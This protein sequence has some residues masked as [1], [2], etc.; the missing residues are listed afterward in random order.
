MKKNLLFIALVFIL[1]SFA[2]AQ[3]SSITVWPGTSGNIVT[4]LSSFNANEAIYLSSEVGSTNFLTAGTAINRIGFNLATVAAVTSFA[5][6]N[7]YL[8]EVP[9]STTDMASGIY[10]TTGY[11]LVYSGTL[12]A[13]AV[14]WNYVNLTTPFVRTVGSDNVQILLERTTAASGTGILWNASIGNANDALATTTHLTSRRFSGTSAPV[15]GTTNLVGSGFRPMVYFA[16]QIPNDAAYVG[17]SNFPTFS[18][19]ATTQSITTTITN[20]GTSTINIGDA[21]LTLTVTTAN[22]GTYTASNTTAIAPGA[23]GTVT[24]TGINLNNAGTSNFSV[25]ISLAGDTNTSDNNGT[26]SVITTPTI[27]TFPSLEDVETTGLNSF[28]WVSTISGTRQLWGI[29]STAYTNTDQTAA[30][31]AHSGTKFMLFDSYSGASSSGFSSKYFS[32]CFAIPATGCP[33]QVSFWMSHDNTT[34]LPELD[35]MYVSVS[36]DKGITWV[37]KNILNIGAG[38]Q[39]HDATLTANAAP[40]WSK[41]IVDLSAYAGQTIQIGFEGVSKY[42]NAFG[43]DDITIEEGLPTNNVA[44][45][46][47]VNTYTLTNNCEDLGWTYYNDASNKNVLAVEWG[48]NTASK[49]AATATLT[50]DATDYATTTGSG[51]TAKGTFTMKRYWNIDVA[52]VQPTTP[53]NVRFFYN[54]AEKT[55]TDAA[56]IAFQATNT[57]SILEPSSWFKTTSG[58]FVGDAAHVNSDLVLN[59]IPLTDANTGA[60]TI[61]GVLYAQFNGLTSF[62]GGTYASGVGPTT[63]LPVGIEFFR[64]SKSSFGNYLNWKVNAISSSI[65]LLVL[66]RSTDGIN[67]KTVYDETATSTRCLQDFSY[68]DA[69]P[70]A[71]KNYYRLKVIE[72]NGS[73]R[74][75]TIVV[76]LNNEKGFELINVTP[77]PSK[78]N[79]VLALTSAKAGK[80]IITVADIVGKIVAT[81]TINVIAGYNSIDLLFQNIN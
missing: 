24:F 30:L 55:A 6:Y 27:S 3:S 22:T 21:T 40:I 63:V 5:G 48:S 69:N 80:Y 61:N 2:I 54:A 1:N 38:L 78:G 67:F 57:G 7:I 50:Y 14:G 77:N 31:N 70:F 71:G 32:D 58:S 26:T 35:S 45:E 25:S 52:G 34:T 15:S 9:A 46:T 47:V 41:N 23:T 74:Y 29:R 11:T 16:H 73:L 66:E 79:A 76:L 28:K 12:V 59:A 44:L 37:R 75:S 65:L 18:C 42:G 20:R 4:G 81:Q 56:A 49:A 17:F 33:Y 39:R 10:S 68:T 62:S 64:G 60:A 43:L 72:T 51:A 13:N 36:V 19:H 53:V 8:K